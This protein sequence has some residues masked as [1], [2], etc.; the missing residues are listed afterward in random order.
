MKILR[1]DARLPEYMTEGASGADIFACPEDDIEIQ[2]GR[3]AI[4]PTGIA[5][6]V[7]EGFELQIRP[8]SGLAAEHG[9]TLL[10]SPGTIDS[11][12]RGEIRIIVINAGDRPFVIRRGMRIA[13]AVLARTFRA[14]WR[15][16]EELEPTPRF[17]GGFGHT[18][19]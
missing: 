2:P 7:P 14:R 3:W 1:K 15:P 12:Y 8:R 18:G 5:V 16:A 17:S 4:V 9:I 6:S 11:D 19:M 10:N 13:Q